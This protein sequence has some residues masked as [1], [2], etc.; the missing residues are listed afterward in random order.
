MSQHA[1]VR[2]QDAVKVAA[3]YLVLALLPLGVGEIAARSAGLER[4]SRLDEWTCGLGMI[5][6]A[7][8]ALSFFLR[9]GVEPVFPHLVGR[10]G[11][12]GVR[13]GQ[14]A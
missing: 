8:V 9:E 5:G 10:P 14:F 6:F 2:Q 3:L 12:A 13:A 11:R 7:L 4:R 1:G